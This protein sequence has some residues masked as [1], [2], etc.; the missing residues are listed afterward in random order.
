M[1]ELVGRSCSLLK[2]LLLWLW[3]FS[4]SYLVNRYCR[5]HC[6]EKSWLAYSLGRASGA[7]CRRW[8]VEFGCA[9]CDVLATGACPDRDSRSMSEIAC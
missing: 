9:A 2:P 3:P 1:W 7:H 5:H 6:S 8:R 4:F